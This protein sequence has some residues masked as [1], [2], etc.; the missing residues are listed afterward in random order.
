VINKNILIKFFVVLWMAFTG[1]KSV[2]QSSNENID[3]YLVFQSHSITSRYEIEHSPWTE[4]LLRGVYYSGKSNRVAARRDD[5]SRN[6]GTKLSTGSKSR[7]RYESNR[8][9]FHTFDEKVEEYVSLYRQALQDTV[10]R[11]DYGL[12]SRDEQLAFWLNLYNSIVV[13]EVAKAYPVRRPD[14]IRVGQKKERLFQADVVTVNGVTLSLD[15]IRYR[16]VY[17]YW[18]DPNVIYGFWDGSIGSPNI[19]KV[20]YSGSSVRSQ[21]RTNGREFVNSLRGV[22]RIRGEIRVSPLYFNAKQYFPNWPEELYQ[23]LYQH[24]D[25]AVADV[26]DAKPNKL[27]PLRFDFNTADVNAGETVRY[28]GND[29]A[30]VVAAGVAL[31]GKWSRLSSAGLRGGLSGEAQKF[32]RKSTERQEKSPRGRVII[33]DIQTDDGPSDSEKLRIE[34]DPAASDGK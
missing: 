13:D 9:L 22:D 16:I 34:E 7:Y 27:R 18:R 1:S 2:A 20:A 23:H 17:R 6:S 24:A 19:Q 10:N 25:N 30:A 14:R 8:V 33:L 3:P 31:G 11:I 15:D 32:Q 26:I 29:N 4:F 21:L 28:T 12:L 5:G